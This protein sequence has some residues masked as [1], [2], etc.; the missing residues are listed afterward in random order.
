MKLEI[1][2]SIG[3]GLP[4]FFRPLFWSYDFD[5][6]DPIKHKKTVILN[7]INYGDLKHWSWIIRFYGREV[8]KDML[9]ALPATELRPQARNLAGVFFGLD[10]FNYAPRGAHR[11]R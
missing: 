9:A 11:R 7:T 6:L 2:P 5:S 4:D 8:V 3:T 1:S 10:N